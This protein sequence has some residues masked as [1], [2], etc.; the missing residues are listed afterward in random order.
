MKNPNFCQLF[1]IAIVRNMSYLMCEIAFTFRFNLFLKQCLE[2][3]VAF[4]IFHA[5]ADNFLSDLA[6][7]LPSASDLD[8][9]GKFSAY[10]HFA[11]EKRKN[12]A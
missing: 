7:R 2:F 1:V 3:I 10:T 9:L 6:K 12:I 5:I 11:S 4:G 8:K